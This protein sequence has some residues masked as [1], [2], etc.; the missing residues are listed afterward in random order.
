M[1][2]RCIQLR[3][4]QQKKSADESLDLFLK[5]RRLT[6]SRLHVRK[7]V[8]KL[9]RKYE[10]EEEQARQAKRRLREQ[11]QLYEEEIPSG[12][13]LMEVGTRGDEFSTMPQPF[14]KSEC[15]NWFKL[16]VKFSSTENKHAC[17]H[18]GV[19]FDWQEM[20]DSEL[21]AI[22]HMNLRAIAKYRHVDVQHDNSWD[23]VM[24]AQKIIRKAFPSVLNS[25][26]CMD[27]DVEQ[28][29]EEAYSKN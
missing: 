8:I 16:V 5:S 9:V 14:K 7:R 24:A 19:Y 13:K 18:F 1:S 26:C 2:R 3:S 28:V 10:Q 27:V 17:F 23:L 11:R 15:A 21:E 25:A 4:I 22:T 29:M 6:A 12:W 20:H